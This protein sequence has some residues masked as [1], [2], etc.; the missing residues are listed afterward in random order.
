MMGYVVVNKS[1]REDP[2]QMSQT[3]I[4]IGMHTYTYIHIHIQYAYIPVRIPRRRA[5]ESDLKRS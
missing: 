4:N 1:H 2:P 5:E 3:Y